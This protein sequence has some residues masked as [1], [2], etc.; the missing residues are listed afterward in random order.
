MKDFKPRFWLCRLYACMG[1]M[2][3]AGIGLSDP[4]SKHHESLT[5]DGAGGAFALFVLVGFSL[6]TL[7]DTIAHDLFGARQCLFL[8]LRRFRFLWLMG[9]ATGLLG[10]ILVNVQSGEFEP[11]AWRYLL[12]ASFATFLAVADVKTRR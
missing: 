2:V 9:M 11:V 1:V 6:L 4:T 7:I 5:A 12:D 3:T 10:L 8:N